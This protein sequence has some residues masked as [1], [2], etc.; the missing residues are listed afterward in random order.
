MIFGER[1]AGP[2]VHT[3]FEWRKAMTVRVYAM[4]ESFRV[5][6]LPLRNKALLRRQT[7]N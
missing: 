5:R 7:S 2:I 4:E 6:K 3:I 1:L